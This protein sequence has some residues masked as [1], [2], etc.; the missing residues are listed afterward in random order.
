MS[1]LPAWLPSGGRFEEGGSEYVFTCPSCGNPKF[2]WNVR[3]GRGYCF[4]CD[5]KVGSAAYLRRLLGT[6]IPEQEKIVEPEVVAQKRFLE[7]VPVRGTPAEIY[8]ASRLVSVD[9]A[10]EIG[11]LYEPETQRIHAP[12]WSPLKGL[13]PSYKSRSIVPGQK[14]WMSRKGDGGGYLFGASPK[15][16]SMDG[17]V[18]LV[19]GVF[20]VLTPGLWG[21]A[22]A[23]LGSQLL[24]GVEWWLARTYGKVILLLDPDEAG[25]K[26]AKGVESRLVRWGM[27]V[28]NLTG[29]YPEPGSCYNRELHFLREGR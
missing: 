25:T 16:A 5:L 11:I 2:F 7:K 4:R 29:K 6:A 28:E 1:S 23:L 21:R 9:Q 20:D 14:G 17:S 26:K 19:E 15:K 3:G 18:V 22:L 10:E 12:I 24:E 8:L 13:P 27:P